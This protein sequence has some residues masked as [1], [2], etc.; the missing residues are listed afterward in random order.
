[1]LCCLLPT[2]LGAQAE[3]PVYSITPELLKNA[4]VVVRKDE[5]IFRIQ[6]DGDAVLE[7]TY[8]ATILNADGKQ[9]GIAVAGE[10]KF[11]KVK[12]L[13][14]RLFDAA[15]QLVRSTKEEDIQFYG[16]NAEYE[17]NDDQRKYI[18]LEYP[19]FPYT[20]EFRKKTQFK[21]FLFVPASVIQPLGV[22]V[23]HWHYRLEAPADY[24]FKW[25]TTGVTLLAK[26]SKKD[27][28]RIWEW[29]AGQL[30]A[31]PDEPYNPYFNDVFA[32]IDFAAENVRFD[33]ASGQFKD[34]KSAGDFFY[35]LNNN[36]E[37]LSP[38][39]TAQIQN[40]TQGKSTREKIDLLYRITQDQCRYVSIQLGIGGWQTFDAAFV[41]K[42][43]Y[44]DCKA[45]TNYTQALLKACGI[46]AWEASIYSGDEGAPP[47][48]EDFPS[49]RF[50]HVILYVPSEDIWLEC[51]SKTHPAGY[52]G[53]FTADR[54]ALVYTPQ[55]GKLLR[56]PALKPQENFEKKGINLTLKEDG[57]ALIEGKATY[58]GAR[59]TFYRR[60]ALESTREDW[61]KFFTQNSRYTIGK[62]EKADVKASR[63]QTD[64]QLAFRLE[65]PK[66][67]NQ[68]GKRMFVPL[69]KA[70]PFKPSLPANENRA[71]DLCMKDYYVMSDTFVLHFP[72]GYLAE[73]IPSGKKFD[74]EFGYYEVKTEIM[75]ASVKVIRQVEVKPVNV[76]AARYNEVRQ[77]FLDV[78]KADAMQMVLV[79]Q[80]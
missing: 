26:D 56:T 3:Y 20:V 63:D 46:E 65:S 50:N 58:G 53:E 31:L 34:W 44:G 43:K 36:R 47:C 77:F 30:K 6:S 45:L 12:L 35:A 40:L 60:F 4:N 32:R 11:R 64:A 27:D 33:G 55:G 79:K 17:F 37:T 2:L 52:L 59:H 69:T 8:V 61:E 39:F 21:G 48:E 51:T 13:K 57:L 71:L 67:A 29:D 28:T 23:E 49:P 1:M 10:D 18:Q 22:A 24:L 80:E 73:N 75:D 16:G 70:N 72:V 25:K 14:G 19:Q 74:T 5:T 76:S 9:A 42:K 68:S 62:L 7:E 41:E 66:Y 78:A 15:G 54:C 38:E